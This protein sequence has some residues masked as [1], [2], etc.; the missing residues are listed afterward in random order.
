MEVS[1][2]FRAVLGS[3]CNAAVTFFFQR[4]RRRA[5]GL[6]T[7]LRRCPPES[8][9]L[10]SSAGRS[11]DNADVESVEQSPSVVVAVVVV[12]P[13]WT[14]GCPSVRPSVRPSAAVLKHPSDDALR[15]MRPPQFIS[16]RPAQCQQTLLADAAA[17]SR[18]D[19]PTDR[20]DQLVSARQGPVSARNRSAADDV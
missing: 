15:Q 7:H 2:F 9:T 20:P 16:D 5:S 19:R 6:E 12:V 13:L 4:R 8:T 11:N 18:T 3:G 17:N 10:Q 1:G 14:R